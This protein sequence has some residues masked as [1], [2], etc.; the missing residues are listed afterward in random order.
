VPDENI[1]MSRI[2]LHQPLPH[3]ELIRRSSPK[4]C[5]AKSM[6]RVMDREKFHQQIFDEFEGNLVWAV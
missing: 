2:E 3:Q 5:G 1:V 6:T 4:A